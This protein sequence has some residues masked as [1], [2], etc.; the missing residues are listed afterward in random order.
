MPI[1]QPLPFLVA[2]ALLTAPV[3]CAAQTAVSQPKAIEPIT[4]RKTKE[5]GVV[6]GS[7]VE[8]LTA[9]VKSIDL[10]K[11]EVQLRLSD[12]KVATIKV[13]PEVTNLESVER[14]D[15]VS[16]EY[17]TGLVLRMQAVDREDVKPETSSD[18]QRSKMGGVLSG[19][20]FA[21]FRGTV[22]IL[23]IDEVSRIVTLEGPSAKTYVVKVAPDVPLERV[24]VGD[25]LIATFN[26]AIA[27]SVKPTYKP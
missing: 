8:V 10:G 17:K 11:R 7:R 21:R 5:P 18:V 22:K 1:R 2:A 26:A 6:S 16:L 20:Q 27:V 3:L 14:G 15:R 9:N 24:K 23:S 25:K 4:L 19:A 12:G 13:G